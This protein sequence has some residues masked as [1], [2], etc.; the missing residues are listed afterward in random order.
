MIAKSLDTTFLVKA[1][2]ESHKRLFLFDYN[3][4]LTPIVN[5]PADAQPTPNLLHS[6]QL[7]CKNPANIVWIISV[8]INSF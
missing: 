7:L 6:L 3:G 5:N 2:K 8:V 1:Y 4:T